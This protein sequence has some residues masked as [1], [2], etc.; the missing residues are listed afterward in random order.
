MP[1]GI[2]AQ[3]VRVYARCRP[4]GVTSDARNTFL[5]AE[6]DA[7]SCIAAAE[8]DPAA[9]VVTVVKDG[10]GKQFKLDGYLPPES[11]QADVYERVAAHIVKDV[12][13]GYN[14]TIFAYGQ[15][16]TGK[17]HTMLGPQWD[18][19]RD[20]G[21]GDAPEPE[22]AGEG[23]P[24]VRAAA[25]EGEGKE[26]AAVGPVMDERTK[27]IIPRCLD[28]L[29][30]RV[31]GD[32]EHRY[33]V[34]LSY[35]QIYCELVHDLLSSEP[36]SLSLR[37]DAGGQV[38]VEGASS[39]RVTSTRE[40]MALVREGNQNRATAATRMNAHSSRSHAVLFVN[41]ERRARDVAA[42]GAGDAEAQMVTG[43]LFLVDLAGSERAK[44]SGVS[45]L[46]LNELKA[47][48]LSLASLGNCIAALAEKKK[49][50][51]Y[52]D[53]KLTR[54]L[55]GSLG[56]NA[57]TALV[58]TIAP[59]P[60]DVGETISTLSFGQRARKV[61]VRATINMRVDYK[62]MY[63]ALRSRADG[64]DDKTTELNIVIQRLQKEVDTLKTK[65]A[66]V[67]AEREA[68]RAEL[69]GAAASY[70]TSMEAYS[71]GGAESGAAG[72]AAEV[73]ERVNQR[74]E[75]EI[76]RLQKVHAA[77]VSALQERMERS[78]M[79]QQLVAEEAANKASSLELETS[80]LKDECLDA[81][82]NYRKVQEQLVSL[83]AE[84]TKR[85]SE[86]VAELEDTR[87]EADRNA[88]KLAKSQ[89]RIVKAEKAMGDIM[90]RIKTDF[91]TRKQVTEMEALYEEAIQKLVKRVD[92]LEA[93][94]ASGSAGGSRR[95]EDEIPVN[96][97]ATHGARAGMTY[98]V[99]T[100]DPRRSMA[101]SG[102]RVGGAVRAPAVSGGRGSGSRGE[103]GVT[104]TSSF[105]MR[106][107]EMSSGRVR[108]EQER[109]ESRE[110]Q[111]MANIPG[112]APHLAI[113]ASKRGGS[114]GDS[115]GRVSEARRPL[116]T[117]TVG[118]GG[119]GGGAMGGAADDDDLDLA[120][121]RAMLANLIGGGRGGGAAGASM[122]APSSRL[123]QYR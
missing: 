113:R 100:S 20:F 121:S 22:A 12:M 43:T 38:Y 117:A 74:W 80:D 68:A 61:A 70:A 32:T 116:P 37:E 90:A 45:G 19:E 3:R 41:V 91:V 58:V 9:G 114:G 46:R 66:A 53:S 67:E 75:Q 42:D 79:S 55:Q 83:D 73:I 108:G 2:K 47:I 86:L 81:L 99:D 104:G 93:G 63:E 105:T 98:T 27:G 40:C 29:F 64:E 5:T 16:G 48:N 112:V 115:R 77:E 69:R 88:E 123:N 24:A 4:S 89:D 51:P 65:L 30:A 18:P 13:Q 26:A 96:T 71:K 8:S 15:T 36:G 82:I 120:E 25:G 14:G 119:G 35:V 10:T 78:L 44:K 31:A 109:K 103:A 54:L 87:A 56:G 1:T 85:T 39:M 122:K 106:S 94:G 60:D 34:T 21:A 7:A 23:S 62:S 84:H 6:G 97:R 102:R 33:M 11:S 76:E 101:Q 28:D 52:R 95:D 72:G 57:K 17:T 92:V 59:T 118:A 111:R 110:R 107:T 50:I 49:H